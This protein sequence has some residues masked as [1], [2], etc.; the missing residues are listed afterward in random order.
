MAFIGLF[1]L[2]ITFGFCFTV[3][4][5]I[6]LA[7]L[8]LLSLRKKDVPEQPK[9]KKESQPVYYIVERKRRAKTSYSEPKEI[10]FKK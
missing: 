8:G 7:Y 10:Q 1:Y 5:F 6:K 9:E 3:V 2:I 4:H